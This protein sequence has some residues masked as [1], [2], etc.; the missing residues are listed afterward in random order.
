MQRY[1][2]DLTKEE[3]IAKGSIFINGEDVHHLSNVMRMKAG[4][5]IL[6]LTT[7]GFEVL[8]KIDTITKEEVICHVEGWTNQDRE[9]PVRVTIA[10]G[11]PKGD[12][13]EL[14]IQKGTELGASAFIPFQAARS[15]TK[16]DQKKS[17]KKRERWEKIAKEAAEQSYRNIIPRVDPVST[18][19]ELTQLAG[20]FDKCVVAY[21]ESSKEGEQSR[22]QTVLQQ[23][24]GGQTLLVVFGPEGG[25]AEKEIEALETHGAVICGLGPRILRTETAPLYALSAISYQTELL[26]GES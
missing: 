7:D 22:F 8:S 15:I 6:C 13:L 11:L 17:H 2:I 19:K 14:I 21:E 4:Q 23:M 12:K 3:V 16:L 18:F 5:E 26:R 20:E 25:L 9:L 1:F 24:K 10:S